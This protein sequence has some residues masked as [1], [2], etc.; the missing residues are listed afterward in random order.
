MLTY[1]I[2]SFLEQPSILSSFRQLEERS[3]FLLESSVL[4]NNQAKETHFGVANTDPPHSKIYIPPFNQHKSIL[5]TEA[6]LEYLY[7]SSQ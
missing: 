6:S 7:L 2:S 1:G 4:K 5:F 3:K